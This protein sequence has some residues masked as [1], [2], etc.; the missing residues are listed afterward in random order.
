M[1]QINNRS[2]ILPR[3]KLEVINVYSEPCGVSSINYGLA[4]TYSELVDPSRTV[5]GLTGLFCSSVTDL[6][7]KV[8]WC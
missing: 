2:D 8:T 1:E 6:L 3:Y 7:A 4:N 5:V